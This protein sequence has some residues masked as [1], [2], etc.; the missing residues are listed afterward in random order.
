MAR[1]SFVFRMVMETHKIYVELE[2]VVLLFVKIAVLFGSRR[3]EGIRI[4]HENH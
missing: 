3:Y 1:R 4:R 2:V